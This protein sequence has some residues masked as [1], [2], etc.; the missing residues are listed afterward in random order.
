MEHYKAT[1]EK[2]P[3]REA[4]T[5][6]SQPM[7]PHG[8]ARSKFKFTRTK[9][10]TTATGLTRRPGTGTEFT[11][12]SQRVRSAKNKDH[13]SYGGRATL[14][15]CPF[16]MPSEELPGAHHMKLEKTSKQTQDFVLHFIVFAC[17]GEREARAGVLGSTGNIQAR[18]NKQALIPF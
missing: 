11:S 1:G 5:Q 9:K 15:R 4:R 14:R 2:L 17:L 6:A 18:K 10:A 12:Q 8:P 16:F 13:L 3:G 7:R